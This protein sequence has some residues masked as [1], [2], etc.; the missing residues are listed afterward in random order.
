VQG[1]ITSGC[2]EDIGRDRVG[3]CLSQSLHQRSSS[4]RDSFLTGHTRGL[5]YLVG[6]IL[7]PAGQEIY[8]I[9]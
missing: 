3:F 8:N 1:G 5:V 6:L 2:A 7:V 4:R 9:I